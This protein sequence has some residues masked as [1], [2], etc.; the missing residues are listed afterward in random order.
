MATVPFART[1]ESIP[2]IRHMFA[3]QDT[4]LPALAAV[5]LMATL[6]FE[7]SDE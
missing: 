7:I 1:D 6:T 2:Q 3:E 4:D 5:P